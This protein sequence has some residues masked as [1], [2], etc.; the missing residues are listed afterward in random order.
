MRRL[1]IAVTAVALASGVG[2]KSMG[3]QMLREPVVSIRDVRLVGFGVTGGT[4]TS[5]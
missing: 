3:R 5:S 1:A 4:L 2:C